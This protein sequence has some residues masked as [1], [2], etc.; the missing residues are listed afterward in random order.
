MGLQRREL[1]TMAAGAQSPYSESFTRED[2]M[3]YASF[4]S[5]RRRGALQGEVGHWTR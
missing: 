4:L 2:L 1:H 3:L 5:K